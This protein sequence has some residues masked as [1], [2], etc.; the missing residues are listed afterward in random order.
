V[1]DHVSIP[2]SDL[3]QSGAFYDAVLEPLGARRRIERTGAVGY[4]T[5]LVPGF[6]LLERKREGATPGPGLHVCFHAASAEQVHAFHE[7]GL[8]RGAK[9]AGA[10]GP[11]PEYT[12]GFYGAF[13]LDPDG[14]KV[15]ATW[16]S[17]LSQG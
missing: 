1:L 17:A 2:V 11:R 9:D 7:A 14:Y 8:A 15:E 12:A 10:P 13:L 3:G 16:R 4:G 6:W 5:G